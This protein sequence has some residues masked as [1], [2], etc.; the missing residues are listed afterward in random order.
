MNCYATL[1]QVSS[2]LTEFVVVSADVLVFLIGASREI[3]G[4]AGRFFFETLGTEIY[5]CTDA[6]TRRGTLDIND[7]LEVTLFESDDACDGLYST[8]WAETDFILEPPNSVPKLRVAVPVWST[9]SLVARRHMYRVTGRWGYGDGISADPW[10]S[11]MSGDLPVVLSIGANARVGYLSAEGVVEVG[12]TLKCG[13]EQLFVSKID[14]ANVTFDRGVNGTMPAVHG[15]AVSIAQ[16]PA[17]VV[18]ACVWMASEGY[19]AARRAGYMSE[20]IGDWS[21]TASTPGVLEELK[22]RMLLRVRR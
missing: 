18:R 21:Y 16:Y 14:G 19:R 20:S 22:Q 13:D 11:A 2:A 9:K 10:K 6:E 15:D 1:D 5:T 8:E 7:I 12:H 4:V 3:D 17:D